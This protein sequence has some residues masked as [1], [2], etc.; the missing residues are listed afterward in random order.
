MDKFGFKRELCAQKYLERIGYTG[1]RECSLENLSALQRA[2]VMNVPYENLDILKGVHLS[3]ATAAVYD[4][5]VNRRRGGYCFELNGLYAWLLEELGYAPV[6]LYG[7]WLKY[8][9]IEI[10]PRRHRIS[11]VALDGKEYICDVGVGLTAP[12]YPLLFEEGLVQEQEGESYRIVSHPK[13]MW[14]VQELLD[15]EWSNLY[16]FSEEAQQ[17]IDFFLPH[18]YCT[19]HPDSIFRNQ[20]MVYVRTK[21]GRNTAAD[22]LDPETCEKVVEFRVSLPGGEVGR[23]IPRCDAEFNW[24]LKEYYGIVL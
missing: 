9:P 21:Y 8:E 6:E 3:L 13:M 16:S 11:R 24:A 2:H 10:P 7:R 4:K 20:T 5:I 14:V 1:S 17:P 18:Y 12:Q 19:T 23:F 15:G 22:V